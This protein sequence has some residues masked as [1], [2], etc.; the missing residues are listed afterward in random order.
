[1]DRHLLPDEIDQLLDGD[2]GPGVA[3]LEAHVRGCGRCRSELDDERRLI[4][5]MEHLPRLGPSSRFSSQVMARVYVFEPWHV[6]LRDSVERWGARLT[7]SSRP[8][9]VLAGAAAVSVA[10]VVSVACVWLVTHLDLVFFTV[11]LLRE[12][13]LVGA[14]VAGAAVVRTLFGDAGLGALRSAAPGAMVT[15]ITIVMA[16]IL[17]AAVVVRSAVVVGR[18]RS[19]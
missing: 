8:V 12:R 7:P 19:A 16:A 11:A 9:R 17:V 6:T 3:T 10:A 5:A 2:A 14:G 1:M 13:L 18:R 15:G 4:D